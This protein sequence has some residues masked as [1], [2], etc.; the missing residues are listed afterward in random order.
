MQDPPSRFVVGVRE[1]DV[2]PAP[3]VEPPKRA[4]SKAL[5]ANVRAIV[6][7]VLALLVV[8]AL[9]GRCT[10]AV[11]ERPAFLGLASTAKGPALLEADRVVVVLHGVGGGKESLERLAEELE[12]L[13][14]PARTRYVFLEA[15]FPRTPGYAWFPTMNPDELAESQRRLDAYVDKLLERGVPADHLYLAGFSQGATMA[16]LIASQ[17]KERLGGYVAFSP[18]TYHIDWGAAAARGAPQRGLLVQGRV[19]GICPISRTEALRDTLTKAHHEVSWVPFP[20]DHFISPE[21]Q[22]ATVAFLRGAAAPPP[23]GAPAAP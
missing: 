12:T 20:G 4:A 18:C 6:P 17:R 10:L 19:D 9:L 22:L 8:A 3:P 1:P 14:A 21:G 7:L 15:P 11:I 2:A 5:E 23:P 16:I 13:G